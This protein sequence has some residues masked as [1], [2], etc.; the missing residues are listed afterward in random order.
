MCLT[1]SLHSSGTVTETGA[2]LSMRQHPLSGPDLPHPQ[3]ASFW[4]VT[5][6]TSASSSFLSG[7]V[8]THIF[9][10]TVL[11]DTLQCV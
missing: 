2:N 7:F 5:K 10:K 11:S 6:K 8:I 4:V 9:P 3:S 1:K